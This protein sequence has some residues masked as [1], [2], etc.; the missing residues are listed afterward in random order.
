MASFY[1]EGNLSPRGGRGRKSRA[2]KGPPKFQ[3]GKECARQPTS[4]K[5]AQGDPQVDLRNAAAGHR[6]RPDNYAAQL[7]FATLTVLFAS[8]ECSGSLTLAVQ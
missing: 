3:V 5:S 1:H 7:S 8:D 6:Q 2:A 4:S